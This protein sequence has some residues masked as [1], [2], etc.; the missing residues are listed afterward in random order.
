MKRRGSALGSSSSTDH[1]G[2]RVGRLG[3]PNGLKGFI[4]LYVETEHLRY[5]EP[6][7]QVHIED[8][9]YT[10]RAVRRGA[11]GY[12]VAFEGVEDREHA[13]EIRGSDVFVPERRA[14]EDHEFWPEELIGL[15]VR[16]GG[17]VV[18]AV[19]HGAAQDRLVI[20]RG[21]TMFEV[22]FVD[23]LVP[24]VDVAGGFVEISEIDGLI[25]PPD[26]R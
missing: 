9:P 5:F 10:V 11:K 3:R 7:S 21:G 24:M 15:E 1:P 13:E 12:E 16:P 19:S 8:R 18:A 2:V 26:R 20:D 23:E 6:R 4:G 14:L 17:G 22:P 25:P